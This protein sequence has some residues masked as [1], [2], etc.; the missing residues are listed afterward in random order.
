MK[1]KD[2]NQQAFFE[3]LRAGLWSDGNPDI[4]IDGSTDWNEVYQLAQDQSV[5]GIVLQG[6]ETVQG[7]WL[8]R[9]YVVRKAF[10]MFR[11]IGDLI[12]HARIFPLDSLRFFPSMLV[13]GV[14][15]EV[16][17]E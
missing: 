14:R 3:L 1:R 16:R 5:Q 9:Q 7:S 17:G 6:I 4:R 12:N 13:N 2:I 15:S 11:R 8:G 10:S